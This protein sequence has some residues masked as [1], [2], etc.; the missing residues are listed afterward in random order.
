MAYLTVDQFKETLVSRPLAVIAQQHIFAGLPY[1]FRD[2]PESNDMLV[3][4]LCDAM[5]VSQQNVV[6]VGSAKVGF[7]LNPD[8][9]PRAFS[10][11]SDIDVIVV[12][13]DLFDRIWM[14]L[15]EWHYPRRGVNLGQVEGGWARLRRKDV[16]WGWL[17]PDQIHYEGLS[18][19]NVL[20]P[21]R[22]ISVKWFNAFQSLSLYP[23]LAAHRVS[24]RLYRTWD[25]ALHYHADGLR[26]IRDRIIAAQKG[27]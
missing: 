12:S 13:E 27:A 15:L 17:E 11:T 4:H 19:P 21:L 26:Q 7:S 23:E 2:E 8:V 18:F 6:I 16:Y 24:G 3:G 20:R 1:V 22:D 10:E 5:D 14:T 9:F 25:H